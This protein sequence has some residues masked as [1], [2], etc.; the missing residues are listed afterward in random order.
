VQDDLHILDLLTCTWSQPETRGDA[1][2]GRSDHIATAHLSHLLYVFGGG[3]AT[4]CFNDLF[5]LDLASM[6]WTVPQCQVTPSTR[7]HPERGLRVRLLGFGIC[8]SC[9]GHFLSPPCQT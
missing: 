4:K 8:P 3:S 7:W 5:V 2:C 6:V 9:K 1:P